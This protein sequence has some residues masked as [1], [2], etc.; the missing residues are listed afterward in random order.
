[1]LP[2]FRKIPLLRSIIRNYEKQKFA[3]QWR[4][5]NGHNLT[6]VGER[7]FPVQAVTVGKA[8]YGMLN[9][10]SVFSNCG[11]KLTI[12]NY[13]SIAPGAWFMLGV[14]H[15]TNTFTTFPLRTRL[16][17]PSPLDATCK[18]PLI[19]EDEVWIGANAMIFSGVTVSK[20][21]IVAAGAVVTKDVPPYAIVGGNPAQII[22]YRFSDE[23][24]KLLLPIKLIDFSDEWL[25]NHIETIYKKIESVDDVL[26]LKRL[27]ES[28]N[29]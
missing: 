27:I 10:M 14:N 7:R 18:G 13:V 26:N 17:G 12:G 25:R 22:K 4:R 16:F 19:I 9:I 24:I 8:T 3:K 28:H 5:L 29:K 20:G 23:I 6:S 21:A 11:E 2:V 1:M 15:Q